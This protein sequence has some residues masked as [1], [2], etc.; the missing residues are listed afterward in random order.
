MG[1]IE[2]DILVDPYSKKT[3]SQTELIIRK[4]FILPKYLPRSKAMMCVGKV[5]IIKMMMPTTVSKDIYT[6]YVLRD[7]NNIEP[8]Y[9]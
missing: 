6:Q 4:V 3:T 7:R 1:Q 5:Y 9:R 8:L 2:W